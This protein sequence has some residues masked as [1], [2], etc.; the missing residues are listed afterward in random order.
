MEGFDGSDPKR[1]GGCGAEDSW[2]P[3]WEM[4]PPL[5]SRGNPIAWFTRSCAVVHVAEIANGGPESGDNAGRRFGETKGGLLG[6]K[7][8]AVGLIGIARGG[9]GITEGMAE[10][11]GD[12]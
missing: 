12:I 9:D 1:S 11:M 3:D 2:R 5:G 10:P 7:L 4:S 6:V 8:G